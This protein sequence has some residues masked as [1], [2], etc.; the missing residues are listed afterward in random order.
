MI[1]KSF[2]SVFFGV[3]GGFSEYLGLDEVYIRFFAILFLLILPLKI[4]LFFIV[5]YIILGLT[6]KKSKNL[7]FDITIEKNKK[8]ELF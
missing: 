7:I 1:Y 8:I 3:L 4:S 5:L 6:M 2:D